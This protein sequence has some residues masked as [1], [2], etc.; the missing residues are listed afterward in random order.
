[1]NNTLIIPFSEAKHAAEGLED[2][3]DIL[4]A[5]MKATKNHWMVANEDE[6]FQAALAA[7]LCLC[8]DEDKERFEKEVRNLKILSSALSGVPVDWGATEE[9]E[10]P[11]GIMDIWNKID[12]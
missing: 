12:D 6:Q 11:I 9:I 2:I 1:M 4:K 7:T 8:K 5:A 10:N 3:E